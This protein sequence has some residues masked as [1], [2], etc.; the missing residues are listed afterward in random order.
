LPNFN[1]NSQNRNSNNRL[2]CSVEDPARFLATLF[3]GM[4][5]HKTK[6]HI[7]YG[8]RADGNSLA[9]MR[10]R[11]GAAGAID[12]PENGRNFRLQRRR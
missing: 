1:R 12:W 10:E 11:A 6:T 5:N 3:I 2:N 7:V 9:R 4:Q 8:F